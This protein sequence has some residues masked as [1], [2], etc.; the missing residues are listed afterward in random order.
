ML[1]QLAGGD[2]WT[3]LPSVYLLAISF[4][5]SCFQL[6]PLLRHFLKPADGQASILSHAMGVTPL[7]NRLY[8]VLRFC[9]E[10]SLL[11]TV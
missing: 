3:L 8:T 10:S 7:N 11:T 6:L 9:V 4:Y 5:I 2:Q 1:V